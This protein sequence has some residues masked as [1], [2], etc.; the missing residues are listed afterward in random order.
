MFKFLKKINPKPVRKVVYDKT[1]SYERSYLS[2]DKDLK[3]NLYNRFTNSCYDTQQFFNGSYTAYGTLTI[4]YKD[5]TNR[6]IK[7]CG[8]DSENKTSAEYN[9]TGVAFPNEN[10]IIQI[11]NYLINKDSMN[12]MVMNLDEVKVEGT[13]DWTLRYKLKGFVV[14][15][16]GASMEYLE[17]LTG[18]KVFKTQNECYEYRNTVLQKLAEAEAEK[19]YKWITNDNT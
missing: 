11:G 5:G 17:R 2:T 7:C 18:E 10:G 14:S 15:E 19:A 8:A 13:E 16:D 12:D 3:E 9:L 4:N 1:A 6:V